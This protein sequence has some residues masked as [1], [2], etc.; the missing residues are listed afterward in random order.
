MNRSRVIRWVVP[1]VLAAVL[2]LP[3]VGSAWLAR[4][5]YFEWMFAP[6]T[7]PRFVR[8]AQAEFS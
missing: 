8:A 7:D 3:I 4:Q 2:A 1:R 6:L 5:N